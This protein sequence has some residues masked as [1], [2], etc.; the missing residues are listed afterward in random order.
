MY[1]TCRP[2]SSFRTQIREGRV[3]TCM[4]SLSP[5]GPGNPSLHGTYSKGSPLRRSSWRRYRANFIGR[6]SNR[7][8]I[9]RAKRH[10][11]ISQNHEVPGEPTVDWHDG[12]DNDG[13][14]EIVDRAFTKNQFEAHFEKWLKHQSAQKWRS[15]CN[16]GG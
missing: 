10:S 14:S 2:Q 4:A 7:G 3:K 16:R 13:G 1:Q 11:M 5:A 6:R 9:G 15:R 12:S 8:P